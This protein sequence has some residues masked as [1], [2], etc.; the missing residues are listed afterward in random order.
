MRWIFLS[1][2][3]GRRNASGVSSE[4]DV[5]ACMHVRHWGP[6]PPQTAHP[7]HT[8]GCRRDGLP[9]NEE[10]RSS[11]CDCADTAPISPPPVSGLRSG[12]NAAVRYPFPRITTY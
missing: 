11:G 8:P 7:N 3:S 5:H 10:S 1:V 12:Q 4:R 6:G 9:R 2:V